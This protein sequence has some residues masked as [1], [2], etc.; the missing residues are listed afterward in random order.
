MARAN[1]PEA[2]AK[3]TVAGNTWCR[4][5]RPVRGRCDRPKPRGWSRPRQAQAA[6][7]YWP[8]SG[9]RMGSPAVVVVVGIVPVRRAERRAAVPVHRGGVVPDRLRESGGG[10]PALGG[11]VGRRFAG[12]VRLAQGPLGTVLADRADPALPATRRSRPE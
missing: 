9:A 6:L 1:K 5:R 7:L 2:P 12:A 8:G 3:I 4:S 10:G 11:V